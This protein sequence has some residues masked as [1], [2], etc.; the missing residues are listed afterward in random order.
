MKPHNELLKAYGMPVF[1]N[2]MYDTVEEALSCP[3]GDILLVQN[4]LTGLIY[5]S[6][7]DPSLVVYDSQYQNE[8]SNSQAFREHLI[9]VASIINNQ[10]AGGELVEVGCGKGGFLEQLTSLGFSVTGM[11][12]AYEGDNP[13]IKKELFTP[14]SAPLADGVIL[15]HVLEHIPDPVSFL[16][17]IRDANG[18]Q[19]LIYIEVPCF[20]WI[21]KKHSW[22]D[23]F[24]EHVNYFRI[25]DFNRMFGRVLIAEHTFGGQYLSVIA[26]LSTLRMPVID[27]VPIEVPAN[28]IEG[29]LLHAKRI[30][31]TSSLP[32]VIWGGA[33]KGVI[34][35]IHMKRLGVKIDAIVDINPAKQNKYI[36]V[37]GM[38]VESPEEM[39]KRLDTEL[40]I[41]VMNPNYLDE[42]RQQSGDRHLY[43]TTDNP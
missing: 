14:G 41:L 22:F 31:E 34:F 2:R 25:S 42:I 23:V 15:R 30:K 35:A 26:D 8:Q 16:A 32:T 20:D 27:E 11:D 37:T 24:Y 12:P 19:G 39:L 9:K 28:F 1:Q 3:T 38:L 33:S 7:F 18:G 10:L 6:K 29:A 21:L 36:A 43:R 4:L 13:K 17:G 5:N 40:D